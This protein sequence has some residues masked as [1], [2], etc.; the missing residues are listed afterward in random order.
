MRRLY[1]SVIDCIGDTPCV[2]LNRM[3]AGIPG[4]L[5]AKIEYMNPANSVKDRIAV[6]IIDE[7]E[8]SGQLKPGGTIIEATSGNTGAGL[9]MVAAVRGYKTIFV[10]ADK[11]SEEKRA[12]LRAYGARVVVCPTD[13]DPEDPRSY[14]KVAKR[15]VEETPNSAYANQYHNPSN[16]EAHYLSTGPEIWEQFEGRIDAFIAGMG[17]GGTISG[18]GRFL[19]EKNPK[20]KII[21]VDP[22]GSLYFDYFHTG[23]LTTAHSYKVEG[24][25]EDF[26]PSTMNFDF[27]DDVVRVNDKECFVATRQ[28]VREEGIFGGSSC[29]AA[30]AG[31]LKWLRLN[32]TPGMRSLVLLPDSG[33][34][35][36]SK[37]YNDNWMRENGYLEPEMGGLGTVHELLEHKGRA[38]EIVTVS[39]NHKIPEVVGL[40]K[41]HGVSQVPV[42]EDSRVVGIVTE[43]RLLE[44]ALAGNR[45]E[46]TVREL[47]QPDF[48][49]VDESTEI[50][51]LIELFKRFKVALVI[52]KGGKPY[53]IITRIDMIDYIA[54]VTG[55]GRQA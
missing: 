21:G 43:N 16:P 44:R 22:V 15:I 49:T 52:E 3:T 28:L 9:A 39:P 46:G 45:G 4:E 14:Y 54:K 12:A 30:A 34:R 26:L 7:L 11:Q 8:R 55:A 6:R 38:S 25:G 18:I 50:S 13:V 20:I 2:R 48:T 10:M 37:V 29:G 5:Y 33:A 51:V 23:Q 53:D 31:A 36:L 19:K 17:T 47:A 40:L 42:M 1:S 32:A 27:V 24:I 35:Y 41:L